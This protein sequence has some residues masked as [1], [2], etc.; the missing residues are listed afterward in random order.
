MASSTA[1]FHNPSLHQSEFRRCKHGLGARRATL[2]TLTL[3][4]RGL[5][6]LPGGKAASATA[7]AASDAR[8]GYQISG[9]ASMLWIGTH[10]VLRVYV[11]CATYK[12]DLDYIL[13]A[14]RTAYSRHSVASLAATSGMICPN[15]IA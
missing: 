3:P 1:P 10:D 6:A 9:F 13:T 5:S 7:P 4:M 12:I 2:M 15:S 11:S 14:A 8:P